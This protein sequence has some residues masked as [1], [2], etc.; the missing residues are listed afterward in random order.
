MVFKSICINRA[1]GYSQQKRTLPI[2][3]HLMGSKVFERDNLHIALYMR[4]QITISVCVC[5]RARLLA[6]VRVCVCVDISLMDP[7]MWM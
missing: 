2:S 7:I 5:V 6:S 3:I 4:M 1:A